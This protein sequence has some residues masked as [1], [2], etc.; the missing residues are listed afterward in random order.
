MR[1]FHTP[2]TAHL[3]TIFAVSDWHIE[4]GPHVFSKLPERDLTRLKS[5]LFLFKNLYLEL[6]ESGSL[7]DSYSRQC[8]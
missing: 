2:D 7:L 6:S 5:R 1:C 4:S 3:R 8:P